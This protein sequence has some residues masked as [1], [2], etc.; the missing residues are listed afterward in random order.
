MAETEP[1]TAEEQSEPSGQVRILEA[2]V[3][4]VKWRLLEEV[5]LHQLTGALLEGERAEV[6]RL[7][8][9][10]G[11]LL[12]GYDD[13]IYLTGKSYDLDECDHPL[14]QERK[15]SRVDEVAE[16]ARRLL[17]VAESCL[18]H[19]DVLRVPPWMALRYRFCPHRI[20]C[21]T[22]GPRR[23]A[24]APGGRGMKCLLDDVRNEEVGDE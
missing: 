7:R 4:G 13:L 1:T 10:L 24:P 12:G 21:G 5:E 3:L 23:P 19:G 14:Y 11:N 16:D 6:E 15:D 9:A 17:G 22:Q 8:E 20:R 2:E 18:G